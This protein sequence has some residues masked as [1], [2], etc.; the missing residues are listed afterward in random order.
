MKN[1]TFI[2]IILL[3]LVL[4]FTSLYKMSIVGADSG[5]DTD[6]DSNDS[7]DSGSDWDSDSSGGNSNFELVDLLLFIYPTVGIAGVAFIPIKKKK[8]KLKN[9]FFIIGFVLIML[10]MN[11]MM[12][13]FKESKAEA[14]FMILFMNGIFL[15]I[16]IPNKKK[17][18]SNTEK[19][20]L[21]N[22]NEIVKEAFVIY[23]KI[24]KAWM[25]FDC[26]MIKN[27]V[28]D[29]LYNMYSSQLETLKIK[30]QQNIMEEITFVDG[31]VINYK[32]V[33]KK[34]ITVVKLVVEC[35]DYIINQTTKEVLRGNKERKLTLEYKLTFEKNI[36]TIKKCPQCGATIKEETKCP[37]CKSKIVNNLDNMVLTKKEIISQK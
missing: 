37:Y 18:T 2:L 5:F 9:I 11:Y 27:L 8:I 14:I 3:T 22:S 6:Y 29:E 26:D 19:I 24:Q 7:W 23:D 36:N 32:K 16:F 33:N 35:Y 21:S 12:F 34:E 17:K 10:L 31:E 13:H 20:E 15:P 30:N 4:T 25:N 28:S 1:N